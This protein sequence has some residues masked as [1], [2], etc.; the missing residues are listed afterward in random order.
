MGR[1]EPRAER[2]RPATLRQGPRPLPLH[3]GLA[4]TAWLGSSAAWTSSNAG[5][6]ISKGPLAER[7]AALA[8]EA[9]RLDPA[10]LAEAIAREGRRRYG[11]F[12][13]GVL[14]YRRHPYRR[15]L[16]DPPEL[17]REGS[18]RLL[19]YAPGG[20]VPVLV[21]PSLVNR[22]Y[23]LDLTPERSLLRRWAAEGLRPLLLDWGRPGEA[24]RGFDLTGYILRLERALDVVIETAGRPAAAV[25]YCMGGLLALA[26]AQ[27][28]AADLGGLV[29]LATPWDFHAERAE[30]ARR[31]GAIGAALMP[32]VEAWGELPLDLLQ[33]FFAMV[34]PMQVPRK[35]LGFAGLDP[36]SD[37]AR[38]FVALEDWLNDGVPLAA[39]VAQE[40]LVGWYGENRPGS[41]SWQ[42]AGEAVRPERLRLPS[43]VVVPGADRIVPPMTALALAERIPAAERL[44]P[45]AGHIGMVVGGG[46][47]R[48]MW[49][50][51]RRWIEARA[52]GAASRS[53]PRAKRA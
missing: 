32:F 40:C 44:D 13:E 20:G 43:L 49:E 18:T 27:R 26:L 47:D 16:T 29:L 51:V 2:G 50:P 9:A 53:R 7:A 24:E 3:L 5:W 4:T 8:Q 6:P 17:W 19:D 46:A 30:E 36:A 38:L 23:V 52:G 31:V 33:A 14:A 28:R 15:A 21:V 35:F 45:H 1:T 37:K 41:G 11:E 10:Q 39:G 25:G 48:L 22:S 12:L 34:D 42:V